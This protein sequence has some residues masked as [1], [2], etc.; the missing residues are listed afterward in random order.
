V[1][2]RSDEVPECRADDDAAH[3]EEEFIHATTL[4]QWADTLGS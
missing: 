2:D 3:G 4:A 1:A